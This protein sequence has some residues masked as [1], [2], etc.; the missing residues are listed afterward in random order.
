MKKTD[1]RRWWV[2]RGF[3]GPTAFITG[4]VIEHCYGFERKGNFGE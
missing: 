2:G 1:I 4:K 3:V